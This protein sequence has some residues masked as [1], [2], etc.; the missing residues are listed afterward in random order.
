MGEMPTGEALRRILLR[1]DGRGYKAYKDIRDGFDFGDLCVWVDHVQGDPFA[2][3]SKLRIRVSQNEARLPP[4]LHA[5]PVR[6]MALSDYLARR[7]R[8]AID[9][10]GGSQRGSGKSGLVSIDAGGQTVLERTAVR[11]T[12]D[13]VEARVEVG[14]PADARR[15]RG[16]DAVELLCRELPE[17]ARRSLCFDTMPA[18]EAE[19][20]VDAIENQEYLRAQLAPMGLVAFVGDGAILPR[21][22]GASDRPLAAGR[23]V[24]FRSPE[25]L[26]VKLPLLHADAGER[27]VTGM[28]IPE[29]VTLIVGGGYHGKSTLL[30]AIARGVHPHVPGDGRDRVVSRRDLVKVRAEDGRRVEGVDIDGFIRELPGG[31]STS[32]FRSDDASGSTSQAAAI[33]EAIEVGARGLLLDEDTSASN[34]MVR[35]ARMQALVDRDSEPITPFVERVREL[36]DTLGVSSVIVMGGS[37]DYFDVADLVVRMREYQPEDVTDDAHDIAAARPTGRQREAT[38]PL[39]PPAPR[40]PQPECF[41]SSRGRRDAMIDVRGADRIRYGNSDV[42]LRHVEQLVDASQTRGVGFAIHLAARRFMKPGAFLSEVLDRLDDFLDAEG[43]DAL[44]PFH[45]PG[46]H[47]GNIARPRRFEVAAAINRMRSLRMTRDDAE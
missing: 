10:G 3:P 42:N 36:K 9:A 24:P 38:T 32:D 25:S 28:G 43:L 41:D 16:R 11:L 8:A 12:P 19:A 34:F 31:S 2:A 4:S 21:K 23:A 29:G 46:R 14:L 40:S 17:I 30:Q 27:E 26:R 37:G 5:N 7:V 35:D 47:P 39:A 13:W 15:V 6:R 18:G 44:D 45:R 22:S 1:I 20:F 33:A